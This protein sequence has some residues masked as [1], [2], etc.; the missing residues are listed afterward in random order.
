MPSL[1]YRIPGES[2]FFE[3][4]DRLWSAPAGAMPCTTAC[5][6]LRSLDRRRFRF[7][8]TNRS[9][10][11][12]SRMK[13]GRDVG[14]GRWLGR[15]NDELSAAAG[16]GLLAWLFNTYY[17]TRAARVS[18]ANWRYDRVSTADPR[19][20]GTLRDQRQL[21]Q[22]DL[23]ATLALGVCSELRCFVA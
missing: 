13:C 1:W 9:Q 7:S 11:R 12:A 5:M 10:D 14:S 18:R 4:P 21:V 15:G 19:R 16:G 17:T 8:T 3:L 2:R 23:L 20:P 6:R 22:H